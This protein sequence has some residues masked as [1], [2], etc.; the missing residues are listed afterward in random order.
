V[1]RSWKSWKSCK[2]EVGAHQDA[3]NLMCLNIIKL[4]E[5]IAVAGEHFISYI[6]IIASTFFNEL[7]LCKD[8]QPLNNRAWS[9]GM[10]CA[11][12]LLKFSTRHRKD[13]RSV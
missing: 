11:S 6:Q 1:K 2:V 3:V 5:S 4:Q 13:T 12:P 9:R 7:L 10:S 8:P